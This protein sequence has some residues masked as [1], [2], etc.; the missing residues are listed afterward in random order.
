[1]LCRD[2]EELY[3]VNYSDEVL[4]FVSSGSGGSQTIGN[5]SVMTV[6]GPKYVY[7]SVKVNEAVKVTAVS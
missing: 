1:M 7:E 3:F 6:S 5:D 2:G 4:D